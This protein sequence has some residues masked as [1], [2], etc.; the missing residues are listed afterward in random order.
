[1]IDELE[2]P[3][4][5]YAIPAKKLC[6]GN[7]LV[8]TSAPVEATTNGTLSG[9]LSPLE[10]ERIRRDNQRGVFCLCRRKDGAQD[11]DDVMIE[12]DNCNDW[13]HGK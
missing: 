9:E 10:L 13:L 3:Q 8:K 11:L 5:S 12:C 1:M 7:G 6:L 2:V 4:L